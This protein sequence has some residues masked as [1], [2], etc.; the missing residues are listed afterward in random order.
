M[1]W[2]YMFVANNAYNLGAQKS[3]L[4][5]MEEGLLMAHNRYSIKEI[6]M[7]E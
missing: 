2:K 4:P 7:D 1:E 5:N 3:V 6:L